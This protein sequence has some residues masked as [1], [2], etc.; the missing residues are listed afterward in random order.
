MVNVKNNN[1]YYKKQLYS[2]IGCK[3]PEVP[4]G[5]IVQTEI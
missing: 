2:K 1:Y 5:Y 4:N 3:V